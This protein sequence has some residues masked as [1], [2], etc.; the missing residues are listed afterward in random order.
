MPNNKE[1]L[2]N[3]TQM[4]MNDNKQ[5][6]IINHNHNRNV[7]VSSKELI[8]ESQRKAIEN[9][10]AFVKQHG[11]ALEQTVRDRSRNDP[12]FRFDANFCQ[13]LIVVQYLIIICFCYL[14]L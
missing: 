2:P 6:H 4:M 8:D 3:M 14:N 9:L 13:Y 1:V 7:N 5:N 12:K 10:A 11:N